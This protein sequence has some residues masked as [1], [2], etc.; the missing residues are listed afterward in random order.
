MKITHL[1]MDV[2]SVVSIFAMMIGLMYEIYGL[3][4]M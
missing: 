2:I 1:I 3:G 4:W